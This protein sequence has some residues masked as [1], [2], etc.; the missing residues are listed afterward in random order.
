MY[1]ISACCVVLICFHVYSYWMAF[2]DFKMKFSNCIEGFL[3]LKKPSWIHSCTF[4]PAPSLLWS[5]RILWA[6][7][8]IEW[9][10][11]LLN[12]SLTYIWWRTTS[13]QD[14]NCSVFVESSAQYW[15]RQ[16]SNWI[17]N[18]LNAHQSWICLR[19]KSRC[20]NDNWNLCCKSKEKFVF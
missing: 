16:V 15:Y 18:V 4:Y 7:V 12:G 17:S 9:T 8:A 11:V 20:W 2:W 14:V 19:L 10:V 5:F 1:S 3:I 6:Q 13:L